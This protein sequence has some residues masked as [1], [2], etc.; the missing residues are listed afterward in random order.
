MT[1]QCLEHYRVSPD[2]GFSL[3][4][5]AEAIS[6][7]GIFKQMFFAIDPEY[8]NDQFIRIL[9]SKDPVSGTIRKH[10]MVSLEAQLAT[11]MGYNISCAGGENLMVL[12]NVIQRI[13]LSLKT[14]NHSTALAF[15]EAL[16]LQIEVHRVIDLVGHSDSSM[17]I[18]ESSEDQFYSFRFGW[19]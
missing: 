16:R 17:V 19:S 3:L 5:H 1:K 18:S 11:Q 13:I 10:A 15:V 14:S 8:S 6:S 4:R 7:P 2:I 12:L 9:K